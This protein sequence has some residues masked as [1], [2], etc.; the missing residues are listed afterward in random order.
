MWMTEYFSVL[1]FFAIHILIY[2][3]T[4]WNVPENDCKLNTY[5]LKDK[6]MHLWLP[7]CKHETVGE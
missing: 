3:Y 4:E 6:P 1:T 7:K 2:T 5:D